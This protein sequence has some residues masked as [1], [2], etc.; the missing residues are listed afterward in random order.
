MGVLK[1]VGPELVGWAAVL[2]AALSDAQKTGI[3]LMGVAFIV[4]ALVSAFVIPRRWPNFPGRH[5]WAYV[6]VV[7][8][9]FVGMMATIVFVAKEPPEKAEA[10]P[11]ATAPGPPPPAQPPAPPGNPAAGKA[12]F[13]GN[14]CAGCHTFKPAGSTA[15][16]GPDLD[17]LAA[18]AQ[19]ANRGSLDRYTQ[20]SIVDPNAYV[21]PGFNPGLMPQNFKQ[22]LK[23]QQIADLV[24]FLTKG[25]GT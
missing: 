7:I 10:K 20:E 5:V 9:F 22:T 4:F 17:N 25:Q 6:A 2:L 21:V 1:L 18:D 24:A 12:V 23:P 11:P 13:V 14:Q 15:Q 19:K 3:A 8:C 16:V